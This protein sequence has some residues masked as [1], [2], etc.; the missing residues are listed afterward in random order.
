M[1]GWRL[2]YGVMN[3]TVAKH[4]ARLAT[5][6]YSCATV[7]VQRAATVALNGPQDERRRW[8]RNSASAGRSSSRA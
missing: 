8:W 7:F 4:V 3:P 5:N 2:G 6:V 1:T